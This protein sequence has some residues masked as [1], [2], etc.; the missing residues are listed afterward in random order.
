MKTLILQGKSCQKSVKTQI[1][2]PAAPKPTKEYTGQL[3]IP[4]PF[5]KTPP[6]QNLGKSQNNKN[7]PRIFETSKSQKNKNPLTEI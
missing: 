4:P 6:P 1:F 3:K 2:P 5:N 7:P